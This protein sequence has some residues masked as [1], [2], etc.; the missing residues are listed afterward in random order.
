MSQSA[1]I[2][3]RFDIDRL[4]SLMELE[5]LL[6]ACGFFDFFVP[7]YVDPDQL[8]VRRSAIPRRTPKCEVDFQRWF[9]DEAPVADLWLTTSTRDRIPFEHL[10][11]QFQ[12][13]P[14]RMNASWG[15]KLL[16]NTMLDVLDGARIAPKLVFRELCPL[17]AIGGNEHERWNWRQTNTS[18]G[19]QSHLT[20]VLT[21]E[22]TSRVRNLGLALN[23]NSHPWVKYSASTHPSLIAECVER[24]WR[25]IIVEVTNVV[26]G[27]SACTSVF[28]HVSDM[29]P[30]FE[31]TEVLSLLE[32]IPRVEF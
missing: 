19:W 28:A 5:K 2:N 18:Y 8:P 14:E 23:V 9:S 3:I 10:Q 1:S 4:G 20:A 22:R 7:Q 27:T 32:R 29:N 17:I 13:R 12:D 15:V 30:T 6:M 25:R 24:N 16:G 21:I 31:G 26:K 11:H